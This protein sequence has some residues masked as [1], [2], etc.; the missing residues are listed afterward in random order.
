MENRDWDIL[1]AARK[2]AEFRTIGRVY[3]I[4]PKAGDFRVDGFPGGPIEFD[5]GEGLISYLSEND[6]KT[7]V[8]MDMIWYERAA[9]AWNELPIRAGRSDNPTAHLCAA[10]LCRPAEPARPGARELP[11]MRRLMEAPYVEEHANPRYL[12]DYIRQNGAE[13]RALHA[14]A[15]AEERPLYA[16]RGCA[17]VIARLL[18]APIPIPPGV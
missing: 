16:L 12:D 10:L 9:R 6:A 17:A 14:R 2:V 3:P 13:L 1:S 7:L 4:A 18:K 15:L 5:D 8:R 11:L